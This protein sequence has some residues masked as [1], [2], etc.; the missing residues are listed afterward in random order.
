MLLINQTI[1][2]FLI[3]GSDRLN[4][5]FARLDD[6]IVVDTHYLLLLVSLCDSLYFNSVL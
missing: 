1:N 4:L 2:A 3:V 5:I 6:L